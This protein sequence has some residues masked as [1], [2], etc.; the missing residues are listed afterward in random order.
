MAK[1]SGRGPLLDLVE[2]LCRIQFRLIGLVS[3][4]HSSM[5]QITVAPSISAHV[6]LKY[7]LCV[8]C[9]KALSSGLRI[10]LYV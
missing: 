7:S 5:S 10:R 3:L 8:S 6:I 1:N 4:R 2:V 9:F